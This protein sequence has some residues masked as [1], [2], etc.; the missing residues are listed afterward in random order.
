ME[1]SSPDDSSL[2]VVSGTTGA[3]AGWGPLA[4]FEVTNRAVVEDAGNKRED[5]AMP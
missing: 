5:E 1:D 3:T 2:L 4:S